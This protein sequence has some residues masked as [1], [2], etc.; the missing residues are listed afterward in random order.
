[1]SAR[2]TSQQRA[3][4]RRPAFRL[5]APY[6]FT[7]DGDGSRPWS[8]PVPLLRGTEQAPSW[9]FDTACGVEA[10]SPDAEDAVRALTD[11]CADPTLHRGVRLRTGDLL[12]IDN[13]R[14]AHSRSTFEA[15]FDGADRWLQRV[16]VRHAIAPLPT[17][18]A[19]S[20]RVLT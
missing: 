14:C 7:R 16:Y 2:L 9:A 15:R 10:V 19:D 11:A 18:S 13:T 12:A 1:V 17:A 4:L 3:T 5:K 20:Y 6:S 8:A